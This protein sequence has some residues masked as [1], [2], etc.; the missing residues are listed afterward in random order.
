MILTKLASL[1]SASRIKKIR[2]YDTDAEAIQK[3]QLRQLLHTAKATEWGRKYDYSKR[4]TSCEYAQRV[5]VQSYE[6]FRP[7]ID[8]LLAGERNVIWPGAFDWFSKSSGTTDDKS[9][10]IPVSRETF[11]R[12]HYRGAADSIALY[13]HNT[14]GSR[15]FSG[16]GLVLGGAYSPSNVNK[17]IR[18]GD[19]SSLLIDNASPL[20]DLVRV[21]GKKIILMDDW[22]K[23]LQKTIEATVKENITSFSGIPSWFLILCKTILQQTGKKDLTEIWPN[24]EVYFHGGISFAPYRNQFKSLIPKESM[25]YMEIYNASEGFFAIQND[26]SDPGMLLMIDYGIY[27]EFVPLEELDKEYP[28]AVPLWDVEMRKT[29][30]MVISTNSG[31][32]RYLIGDTVQ[33]TSLH[34]HKIV[35]VG[36]TRHFINICGEEL[37]IGNTEKGLELACAQTG[38]KVREYT[39]GPVFMSDDTKARHHWVIEFEKMPDEIEHFTEVLDKAL[40]SLNSDYESKRKKNLTFDRL[41]ITAARDNLFYDWMKQQG[42][43]GGQH[44]VPRLSNER[45]FIEELTAMNE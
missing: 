10:Y 18:C 9:K 8:R 41:T 32:W 27:Y 34:P 22:E 38:A 11:N 31:L 23:K 26:L 17:N 29:Y 35:I 13:L 28:C 14:S 44:K 33:F 4:L 40:Q 20:V 21:P 39:V 45:C 19:L 16:Q 1:A 36:R 15:L 25:R 12:V 42:K 37:M 24:I 6:Q 43:L 5:P 7:Y 2:R 30:A 3:K